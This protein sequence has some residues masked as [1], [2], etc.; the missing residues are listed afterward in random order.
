MIVGVIREIKDDENRVGLLPAGVEALVTAGHTVLAETC[1]GSGINF[2]DRGG[3]ALKGVP[4]EW[5][6]YAVLD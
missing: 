1:C 6:L 4:D 2:E 3:F 5:N